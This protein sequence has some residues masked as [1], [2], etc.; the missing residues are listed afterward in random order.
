M[1]DILGVF[2]LTLIAVALIVGAIAVGSSWMARQQ[3]NQL[4]TLAS[5]Y[6]FKWNFWTGCLVEMP[7]GFWVS[8]KEAEHIMLEQI[9]REQ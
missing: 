8:V 9:G 2:L 1:K 6:E 3:C 7:N 5:D 4:S